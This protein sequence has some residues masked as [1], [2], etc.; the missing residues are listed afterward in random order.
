M[1]I[2]NMGVLAP[3]I[4]H[5]WN[6]S[7]DGRGMFSKGGKVARVIPIYKGKNLDTPLYTNYCPISLLPI[8]GKILE[9]IMYNQLMEF[10]ISSSTL[11]RLQYGFRGKHSTIH[12]MLDFVNFT[13]EGVDGGEVVYGVFCDLS[14][15][16]DTLNHENLL[17]KLHHYGI[18]GNAQAWL[19]SYL[20]DRTQYVHWMGK[21]YERL[22]L[23]TGVSQGSVLG[24][25]LFLIYIN[26]LPSCTDT[27]KVVLFADDSNLILKGD[28]PKILAETV[29]TE[30][31]KVND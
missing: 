10:F 29:T 9:R 2:E 16:F 15:A 3:S 12:A 1:I 24:L 14:K 22:L 7:I 23:S 8:V 25:L 20:T 31:E 19:W 30:L 21:S 13:A 28:D 5:I 27:L 26:D 17:K 4:A 18:R 6:Q 11:Y